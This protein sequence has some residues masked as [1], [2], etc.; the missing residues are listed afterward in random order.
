MELL[1]QARMNFMYQ[2]PY[3]DLM[4][5]MLGKH[6]TP[7]EKARLLESIKDDVTNRVPKEMIEHGQTVGGLSVIIAK[8]LT[9]A[10]VMKELQDHELR[11][12][13]NGD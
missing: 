5:D 13:G 6:K 7:E 1:G 10:L 11:D 8:L 2:V 12:K 4:D 9:Y 3:R